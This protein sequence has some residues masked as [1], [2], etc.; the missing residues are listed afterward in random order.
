[1]TT[2]ER[3][4]APRLASTFARSRADRKTT[5][6]VNDIAADPGDVP[7]KARRTTALG[8]KERDDGD[9]AKRCLA[10]IE[11]C[12]CRLMAAATRADRGVGLC[13]RVTK[14]WLKLEAAQTGISGDDHWQFC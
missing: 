1:M 9:S 11:I 12:F 8:E 3:P 4:P 7:S 14:V 5:G 13:R 2:E 6:D 10:R